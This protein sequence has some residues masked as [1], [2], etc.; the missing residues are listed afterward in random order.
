VAPVAR[1]R[2]P[3]LHVGRRRQIPRIL[4]KRLERQ[5]GGFVQGA[6][7]KPRR[8]RARLGV[9]DHH[10]G[11][12]TQ[13]SRTG[14]PPGGRRAPNQN[15]EGAEGKASMSGPSRRAHP[16]FADEGRAHS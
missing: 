10:R 7:R 4:E 14:R 9:S 15:D 6:G 1:P 16:A 13:T 12:R 5:I 8:W 3:A 2:H 11:L